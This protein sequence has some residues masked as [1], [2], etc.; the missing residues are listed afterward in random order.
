MGNAYTVLPPP[1]NRAAAVTTLKAW[2][3]DPRQDNANLLFFNTLGVF[4]VT[5]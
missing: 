5:A 2:T 1:V 3:V 4:P